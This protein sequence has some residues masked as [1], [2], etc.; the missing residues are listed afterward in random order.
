MPTAVPM[1]TSTALSIISC[2]NSWTSEA[3]NAARVAN[4][5]RRRVFRAS[6]KLARLAHAIA[7]NSPQAPSVIRSAGFVSVPTI[8]ST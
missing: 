8:S 2:W 7:S 3:P 6:N 4:S 1:L 5:P